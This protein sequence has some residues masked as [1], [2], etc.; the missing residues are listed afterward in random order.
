MPPG[1]AE[2]KLVLGSAGASPSHFKH[3]KAHQWRFAQ[4]MFKCAKPR[5]RVYQAFQHNQELCCGESAIGSKITD[6]PRGG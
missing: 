2:L 3:A 1:V 6:V 4:S 5:H